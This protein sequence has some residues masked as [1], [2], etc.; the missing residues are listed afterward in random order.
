VTQT[1]VTN[2][3][4]GGGFSVMPSLDLELE[5]FK[6]YKKSYSVRTIIAMDMGSGKMNYNYFDLG[7]NRYYK[8]RGLTLNYETKDQKII[9]KPKVRMY[10]GFDVGLSRVA[11]FD[12]TTVLSAVSTGIDAGAHWGY[13]KQLTDNWAFNAQVGLSYAYGFTTISATGMNLKFLFGLTTPL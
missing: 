1:N 8:G 4:E 9:I 5:F 11:V 10:Y 2:N 6:S 12:F 13:T 3:L 7:T